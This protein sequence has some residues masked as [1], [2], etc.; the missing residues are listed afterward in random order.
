MTFSPQRN[1]KNQ[2]QKELGSVQLFCA[3]QWGGR[4]TTYLITKSF[5]SNDSDFV[6]DALIG[7]E[8]EGEFRVIPLDDH[9]R[10]FLDSLFFFFFSFS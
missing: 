6:A 1:Q 2:N 10:G 9:F 8:I 3:Q 7:L 4:T 5:R